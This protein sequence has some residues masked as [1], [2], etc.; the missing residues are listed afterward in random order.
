MEVNPHSLHMC[1]QCPPTCLRLYMTMTMISQSARHTVTL[2][3]RWRAPARAN[4]PA[5]SRTGRNE[6]A[7]KAK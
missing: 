4:R 6:L 1:V 7:N 3:A 2:T 5:R